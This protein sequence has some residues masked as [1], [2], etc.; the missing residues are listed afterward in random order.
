MVERRVEELTTEAEWTAALPILRQ[1]WTDADEAFVR[2]WADE[3]DYRLFGLVADGSLVAVAGISVQRVLHH[4]RHAWIHD[5]VVDEAHRGESY[6]ADLL[7]F[8][9]SWA[10][11]RDCEYVALAVRDGNDDALAFYESEGM[12]RWGHVVETEL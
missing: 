2:S 11:D 8:V 9:E 12:D 1:L 3:D 7:G 5:F 6:G 4:A 10:D